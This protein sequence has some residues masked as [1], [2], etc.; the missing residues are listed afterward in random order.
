VTRG[1]PSPAADGED[2]RMTTN[3]SIESKFRPSGAQ[4]LC[5]CGLRAGRPLRRSGV[6]R[7]SICNLESRL[8]LKT[9]TPVFHPAKA[10]NSRNSAL[11]RHRLFFLNYST[12]RTPRAMNP[13][14]S[15]QSRGRP[16]REP[17]RGP[18]TENKK[19]PL[20]LRASVVNFFRYSSFP[21]TPYRRPSA[22]SA[23]TRS[24]D[25]PLRSLPLNSA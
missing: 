20:R 2:S 4:Y 11:F 14:N 16:K 9:P 12:C 15:P 18:E 5:A 1:W 21:P 10:E 13:R 23:D 7:N 19:L 8:N 25:F 6:R 22:P 24:S 17:E 3:I